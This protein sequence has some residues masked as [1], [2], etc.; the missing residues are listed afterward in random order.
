MRADRELLEA[1]VK[2]DILAMEQIVDTY[3]DDVYNLCF[4]LTYSRH[5]AD[6]LF[7]NT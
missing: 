2:G 4:R 6:E 3:K 1:F 5:V 7:Q